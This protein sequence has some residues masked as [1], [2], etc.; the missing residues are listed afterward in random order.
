MAIKVTFKYDIGDEVT[1]LSVPPYKYSKSYY[2]KDDYVPK[3][4]KVNG[5]KYQIDVEG[6]PKVLYQLYAYCDD[7]INYHNWIPADYLQGEGT[8]HTEDVEFVGVDG[9]EI[10]IGDFVYGDVYFSAYDSEGED[11]NRPD[12]ALTFARG[13]TVENL[14]YYKTELDHKNDGTPL[15]ECSLRAVFP[16]KSNGWVSSNPVSHVFSVADEKFIND[17]VASCKSHRFNPTIEKWG[18]TRHT[19]FLKYLGVYDDVCECYNNWNK[20]RKKKAAKTKN[21]LNE[22]VSG[23]TAEE[24]AELLRMLNQ[25]K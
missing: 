8:E 25:E 14:V 22:L 4:Y 1:L 15:V 16:E 6:T 13:G 11:I 10:S 5:Y 23:L 18:E 9:R 2:F 7:Y 19:E 17:Y 24:K 3:S 12:V 21:K 20:A